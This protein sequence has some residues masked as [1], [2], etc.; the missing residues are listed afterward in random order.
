LDRSLIGWALKDTALCWKLNP[1]PE[2]DSSKANAFFRDLYLSVSELIS[3]PNHFFFDFEAHE[4][5]AQVE[6]DKRKVLE[7]RFRMSQRDHD[8][9]RTESGEKGPLIRLPV[10]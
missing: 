2:Q 4:H 1:S 6:S 9:W 7:A 10:H 3:T 5:T 8:W